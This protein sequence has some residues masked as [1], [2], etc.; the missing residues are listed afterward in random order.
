MNTKDARDIILLALYA[1]F[2]REDGDYRRVTANLL[3]LEKDKYIWA[4]MCLKTEEYIDGVNW[5]PKEAQSVKRVLA[6]NTK[7]IC[8]TKTGL[9]RA[10]EITGE[11]GRNRRLALAVI[12]DTFKKL[13]LRA[14]TE[15]LMRI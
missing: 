14:L 7:N 9:E 13:G 3:E 12:T 10:R 11:D 1:E 6:L 5:L 2:N 4:M 8:L 15:L